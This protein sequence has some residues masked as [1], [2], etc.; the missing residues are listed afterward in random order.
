MDVEKTLIA[1]EK[2]IRMNGLGISIL[3]V[4]I[5]LLAYGGESLEQGLDLL[6]KKEYECDMML[7]EEMDKLRD[8]DR[9]AFHAT[10]Q[11]LKRNEEEIAAL[12]KQVEELR[13]EL[14]G[15]PR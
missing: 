11:R 12:K 4:C 8:A 13:N 7:A 10:E 9:A 15:L 3:G 14:R 2:A 5:C 1:F 6:K